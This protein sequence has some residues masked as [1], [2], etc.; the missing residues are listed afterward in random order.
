MRDPDA[1][2]ARA[3]VTGDPRA[4][5]HFLIDDRVLD[6]IPTY[7]AEFDR[8]RIL[9]IGAGTG[10]LT[11]RLLAVS[12]TVIAVERDPRLV[13]FLRDEFHEEIDADR[14]V[15][16]EG[17]ARSVSLPAYTVSISNLPYG[18]SSPVLFRLLPQKRP[19][20][21]MV[22]REFAERM[23]ATPGTSSYGR[24]S[25]TVQHYG[26]AEIEETVPKTAFS[27]APAV[28]SAIVTVTPRTPSYEIPD[29][30]LFF[31]IVRAVFT[32][33]R[34]TTRNALRN[35][36]HISG[37]D[38]SDAVIDRLDDAFLAARPGELSSEQFA[39]ITRVASETMGDTS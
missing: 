26:A 1:L 29:E 17:D 18:I 15:I 2:I 21:V 31:A 28:D 35:T 23:V 4:D 20:V 11:D 7:A 6:R 12:N 19:V 13:S 9:E 38:D 33:R 39:H 36:T 10:A 3:G 37:I 14:L 24:L 32:Q 22:Q 25:V 8:S 16:I 34:K 27:P 5:Q 30:E